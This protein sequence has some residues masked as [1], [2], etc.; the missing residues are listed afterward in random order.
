M[1]CSK[2]PP[3]G[4]EEPSKGTLT[5]ELVSL[6]ETAFRRF[7]SERSKISNAMNLADG[8][9]IL[10][11]MLGK[12]G[13]CN[14]T[15]IATHIGITSGAVTGMTDKL[16]QMGLVHR[17][18]SEQDRRVVYFTLTDEGRGLVTRIKEQQYELM[19]ETLAPVNEEELGHVIHFL[20]KINDHT[21]K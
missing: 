18:R 8:Q 14:A 7:K 11:I 9:M 20:Q 6:L 10:L 12:L 21:M 19:I 3:P 13:Q 4:P 17:E 1:S 2:H 16:V 15:D 5:H